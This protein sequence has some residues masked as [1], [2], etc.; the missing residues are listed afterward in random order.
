MLTITKLLD[1]YIYFH[2]FQVPTEEVSGVTT[3]GLLEEVTDLRGS[4]PL[5]GVGQAPMVPF[6]A[7]NPSLILN[8]PMHVSRRRLS[9]RSSNSCTLTIRVRQAQEE[10]V[11][12]METMTLHKGKGQKL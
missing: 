2:V 8:L 10:L 1:N 5:E 12:A 11:R 6:I 7:T 4:D 9:R 3:V